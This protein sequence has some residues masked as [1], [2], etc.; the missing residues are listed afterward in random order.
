[1]DQKDWMGFLK[2]KVPDVAIGYCY[3]LWRES[4]F[5]FV[6]SRPRSSKLG[7]FTYRSNRTIQR[8]TVNHDLNE[9]QF[10]ITY[11]HE[12]AHHRVY[13]RHGTRHQPHGV[14]WKRE[15]QRLMYPLLEMRGVFP[16]DILIPLRRHM[17]NPKASAGAD[18]F[19]MKELRKYDLNT[20][21]NRQEILLSDLKPGTRFEFKARIFEKLETRRTRI[22]CREVS[23]G[24]KYLISG[25]APVEMRQ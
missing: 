15:F 25:H 7:D 8:I 2:G 9:Y 21:Q 24:R 4:P 12:V 18:L 13:A 1:M 22:L 10:L 23:T 20:L 3:T 17:Q 16:I 14:E 11:I 19:L 5:H 6:I